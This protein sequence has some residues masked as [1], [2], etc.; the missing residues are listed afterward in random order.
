MPMRNVVPPPAEAGGF[1][2]HSSVIEVADSSRT[3]DRTIKERRYA[4]AGIPEMILVDLV[5]DRIIGYSE[6][7]DDGHRRILVAGRGEQLPSAMLPCFVF[8]GDTL[9]GLR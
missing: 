1:P 6:P 5:D 3:Y 7:R 2:A 8:D 4:G 9:L